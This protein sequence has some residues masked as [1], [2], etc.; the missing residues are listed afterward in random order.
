MLNKKE[1]K[2]VPSRGKGGSRGGSTI[3]KK[4]P[5]SQEGEKGTQRD[6]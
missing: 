1:R 2:Q 5:K 3:G 4:I 6:V